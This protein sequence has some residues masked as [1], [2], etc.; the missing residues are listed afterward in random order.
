VV[1][2]PGSEGRDPVEDIQTLRTEI[3]LYDE[4]LSNRPWIIVA[5]KMD[6]PG[7]EENL[8]ILRDRFPKVE[9]IPISAAE[10]EGL[11]PLRER[12]AKLIGKIP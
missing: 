4:D 5:N 1:D 9:I 2:T 8:A 11:E 7:A 12:L 3:K 10:E 6:L